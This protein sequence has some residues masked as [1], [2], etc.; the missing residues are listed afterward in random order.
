MVCIESSSPS[1]RCQRKLV[2]NACVSGAVLIALLLPQD[3]FSLTRKKF[4]FVVGVNGDFKAAMAAAATTA[5]S[6]ARYHI[7]FP[8][9]EYSIGQLTGDANQK[10]T[11]PTSNVS[12]IGQ[13]AD[14]TVI[15]NK[16]TTEGIGVTATLYFNKANNLYLQDLTVLNKANYGKPETYSVTGRHVA[17]QEQGNNI[18]YK[19][20][21]LLSTQD[22]YYSKGTKTYWEDGEIHGTTD[23]I[24]GSGDVFFNRLR[25]YAL[26]KSALTAPSST[27]DTWGYVFNECTIDGDASDFTLARSWNDGKAVFL[28]TTMKKLPVAGGWGDPMNSVP[29]VFAE[30]KSKNASGGMVDLSKRRTSYSLDGTTVNLKAVLTD[31]EA[32]KYTLASVMGTWQP[33]NATKQLAAP[34]AKQEGSS[35]KWDDNTNALCWVVLKGGKYLANVIT[36]SYDVSSLAKGDVLTVRAANEMGG[37]GA[38]SNAVTVGTTTAVQGAKASGV[39]HAMDRSAKLLRVSGGAP[40]GMTA[41]LYAL[42]GTARSSTYEATSATQ[43]VEIPVNTLKPGVYVLRYTSAEG[44]STTAIGIW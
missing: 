35:L 41:G 8:D 27:N 7:F 25:I 1:I 34:V 31:A 29:K 11:F 28:N 12:F 20:V 2:R 36:N 37:L 43:G 42:D 19:N 13:S 38:S 44:T 26:K 32:A 23:F 16:S 3:S 6:S 30:Y 40:G 15:Y 18:I 33:Q 17:V 14:K 39:R 22:T 4:N 9:G 21:K 10:T 5:T 24:C